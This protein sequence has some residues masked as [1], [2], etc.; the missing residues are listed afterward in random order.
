MKNKNYWTF[1]IFF[2]FTIV[3]FLKLGTRKGQK[4]LKVDMPLWVVAGHELAAIGARDK[5]FNF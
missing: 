2:V 1:L 3:F 4:V 5:S